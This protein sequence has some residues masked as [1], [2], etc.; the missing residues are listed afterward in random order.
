MKSSAV[1]VIVV[2][3]LLVVG[4]IGYALSTRNNGGSDNTNIA[5]S[6]TNV[7][8]TNKAVN[9]NTNASNVNSSVTPLSRTI[10]V[11][12]SGFNPS[13]F[14]IN[15]ND[16]VTWKNNTS[17]T[18]YVAPDDHPTH[19]KYGSSWP[20]TGAGNISSGQSYAFTFTKAGTYT[21]H[22]HLNSSMTGTIIVQ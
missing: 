7:S 15:V 14:T 6:N 16:T 21:Y 13:S 12:S 5:N 9:Q 17:L 3:V 11:T 4:G 10:S 19:I 2:V 22:N 18:V 20:D 1:W 8:N